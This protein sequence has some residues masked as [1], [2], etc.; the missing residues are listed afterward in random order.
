MRRL[1]RSRYDKKI[2]GV[3]GGLGNY[4]SI[5]P[6]FIRLLVIFIC[7]LT[8]VLPFFVVYLIAALVIPQEPA[9]SPAIE[10]RRLYR[11]SDNRV[12]AG[13]CGGLA[14]IF[15][16]DPTVLRLIIVVIALVTGFFPMILTYLI[17]WG[18]IPEKHS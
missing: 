10:F 11:T 18:L 6:N 13:I 15:R 8:A 3:C 14:Q 2:A 4:F 17:A 5:D 12:I 1:Y 7:I 9:N 16:M